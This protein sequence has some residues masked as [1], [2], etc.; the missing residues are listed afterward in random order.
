MMQRRDVLK[1]LTLGSASLAF[2]VGGRG[3]KAASTGPVMPRRVVFVYTPEGLHANATDRNSQWVQVTSAKDFTP[4]GMAAPLARHRSQMV[5]FQNIATVSANPTHD[6]D[7]GMR[8][9]VETHIGSKAML[10]TNTDVADFT[11]FLCQTPKGESLDIFWVASW[12]KP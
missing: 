10:L 12:V 2:G 11:N 7:N 4:V 9:G 8:G 1:M 3:A 5:M 6:G